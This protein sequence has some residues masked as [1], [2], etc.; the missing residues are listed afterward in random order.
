MAFPA[1]FERA[2]FRLGG[3]RSILLSYGNIITCF[4][5]SFARNFVNPG[6]APRSAQISV[7]YISQVILMINALTVGMRLLVSHLGIAEP[8]VRMNENI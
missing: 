8:V 4:I 5:V 2:A 7:S 3:G 1:R 6:Q